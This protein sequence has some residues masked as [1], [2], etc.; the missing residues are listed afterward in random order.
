MV[1]AFYNG[2][3]Q[4]DM[5]TVKILDIVEFDGIDHLPSTGPNGIQ[6]LFIILILL[7]AIALAA[8]EHYEKTHFEEGK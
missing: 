2:V 1:A 5:A 6:W 4:S 7:S 8:V 3:I